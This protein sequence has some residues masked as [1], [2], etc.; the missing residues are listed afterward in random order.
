MVSTVNTADWQTL[1]KRPRVGVGCLLSSTQY[2]NCVL[3]G[4]RLGSTETDASS[5][6]TCLLVNLHGHNHYPLISREHLPT[7]LH[8]GHGAGRYALP[9]GHL[10]Q[11][12]SWAHCASVEIEEECK[13]NLQESRWQV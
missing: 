6:V 5:A 12:W 4:E 10:E 13:L 8:T 2:P 3:A 11:G 9:G 7:F 1:V